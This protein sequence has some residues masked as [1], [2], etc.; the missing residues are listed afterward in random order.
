MAI[1]QAFRGVLFDT[2]KTGD[3]AGLLVPPRDPLLPAS[4]AAPAGD[5]ALS[6]ARLLQPGPGAG[7]T[8]SA[9]FEQGLLARRESPALYWFS[10]DFPV[11]HRR[12]QC[13]GL[14]ARAS[15]R[16]GRDV[17]AFQ[18]AQGAA[19]APPE[20]AGVEPRLALYS[21]ES[22]PLDELLGPVESGEPL[23]AFT[24]AGGVVHRLWEIAE[25]VLVAAVCERLATARLLLPE[26][27]PVSTAPVLTAMLPA[28]EAGP[29]PCPFARL[30]QVPEEFDF[31]RFFERLG[32]SFDVYPLYGP[33]AIPG[34]L[35]KAAQG[36]VRIALYIH[37]PRRCLL[38]VPKTELPAL[39][40][41][42]HSAAWQQLDSVVLRRRILEPILELDRS[43][44]D[45][46]AWLKPC[47]EVDDAVAQL[48][49]GGPYRI[50][51]LLN[52]ARMTQ[53][54]ELS[55]GGEPLPAW[56]VD[57]RPRLPSGLVLDLEG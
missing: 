10:Q 25:P 34:L 53:I 14:L 22:A 41:N 6:V 17:Y 47:R 35:E 27:A 23:V 51:F 39:P 4:P 26:P 44:Q 7:L 32:A 55:R 19:A 28:S 48:Q 13:R 29:R 33:E 20:G 37:K 15:L 24:D 40:E 38:T 16:P 9:W 11:G 52:P 8:A 46:P 54:L 36:E 5:E 2:R 45:D 1:V 43:R 30:A 18:D 42:G 31:N 21:G 12:R 50:A 57:F 49:A 56:S 3:L